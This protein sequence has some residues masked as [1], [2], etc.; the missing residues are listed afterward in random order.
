M[1]S[2]HQE[3]GA[4]LRARQQELQE[5]LEGEDAHLPALQLALAVAPLRRL[6]SWAVPTDEALEV[7][8]AASPCGVVE[9]G[10]GAGLWAHSLQQRGVNVAAFDRCGASRLNCYNGE[11][12]PFAPVLRGKKVVP[13]AYPECTLLLC[14]PPSEAG[15]YGSRDT[16]TASLG[17]DAL[18]SYR[19]NT[20]VYVGELRSGGA[21][22]GRLFHSELAN[23]FVLQH[24][25][26]LPNWPGA[27]DNL[28]M[29]RRKHV[30]TEFALN[31]HVKW[32]KPTTVGHPPD[33]EAETVAQ[34]AAM[35][36]A[37]NASWAGAAA[38][39]IS[40]RRLAGGGG[41]ANAV[42]RRLVD[43][44]CRRAPIMRR[45]LLRLLCR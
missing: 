23:D 38:A 21:T 20:V 17:V 28:T 44:A 37:I 33:K 18:K 1:L 22:G 12:P 24:T 39:H 41:A 43:E 26:A 11:S 7:I 9:V 25:V 16:S 13:A 19:G 40:S 45:L 27:V 36:D 8:A 5:L 34:R 30:R 10:A 32:P 29:W 15:T 14:W 35:L 4:L 31:L 42:E 2:P 6:Y 3:L